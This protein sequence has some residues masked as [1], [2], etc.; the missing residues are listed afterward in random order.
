MR[1]RKPGRKVVRQFIARKAQQRA[2]GGIERNVDDAV[3]AAEDAARIADFG[4][5]RHEE[6]A[7]NAFMGFD[8]PEEEAQEP[9]DFRK[10]LGLIETGRERRIAFVDEKHQRAFLKALQPVG[11][12]AQRRQSQRR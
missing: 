9:P 1:L 11:P 2:V 7:Q 10:E 4:D 12:Q 6:E 5:A 8:R 3:E